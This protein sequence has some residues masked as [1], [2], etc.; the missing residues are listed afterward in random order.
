MT[1]PDVVPIVDTH[2]HLWDLSRFSLPWTKGNERLGRDFLMSDYRQ[3]TAGLG[4]E[5]TVYMEVDVD[6]AQQEA[7]ARYVI[8]FCER[9][10]NPM[11]GAVISG[12]PASDG[13]RDYVNGLKASPYIKGVRQVLHSDATPPSYFL[14][15]RFVRGIQ[16]LGE[17]GWSF[18]LCLQPQALLDA[19]QL[20][21]QC[22]HTRFIVDHCGNMSVQEGDTPRRRR[23][24]E[25]M[26]HLADHDHVV[27]KVSGIVATAQ[28]DWTAADL[29]PNINFTLET[30]GADRVMF[31]GDWPVCT[32][33]ATFGQWVGALQEIVKERSAAEKQKLFHDNAVKFYGLPATGKKHS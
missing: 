6:P 27:C 12:R 22:P 28:E 26:R 15:R 2:Q 8:E 19:D 13:F 31:G 5:Q 18:D 17:V 14:D 4:V 7:E 3:A 24:M 32:E 10:D 11:T 23:W 33:R 25:G 29:A 20:V 30:F 21:A 1:A 16:Y 9:G